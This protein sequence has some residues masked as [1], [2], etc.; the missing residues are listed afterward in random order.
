MLY[1]TIEC[2][3]PKTGLRWAHRVSDPEESKKAILTW[4][5]NLQVTITHHEREDKPMKKNASKNG[6]PDI[7]VSEEVE[8]LP[9]I[10]DAERKRMFVAYGK[11][12][13]EIDKLKEELEKLL[14]ARSSL[15]EEIATKCG[16]GPFSF[17]GQVLTVVA[18]TTKATGQQTWFFKGPASTDVIDVG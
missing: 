15:V 12:T 4:Y 3:D 6:S 10:S 11:A 7:T 1:A 2:F 14:A 5:P 16:R 13:A 18:R 8:A 17:K 9:E